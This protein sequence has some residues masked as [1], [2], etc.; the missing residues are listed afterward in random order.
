LSPHGVHPGGGDLN[1]FAIAKQTAKKPF[2]H[3]AAAN[4]SSTNEKDAFH[5]FKPA[6]H[7]FRNLKFKPNQVNEGAV[8]S[9]SL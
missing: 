3:G 5:G 6:R 1:V 2:R 9:A 8:F 4:I 7:R